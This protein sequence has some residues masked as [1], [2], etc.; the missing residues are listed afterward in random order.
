[1]ILEIL[2]LLRDVLDIRPINYEGKF[3]CYNTVGIFTT[4]D[5]ELIQDRWQNIKFLRKRILSS[6]LEYLLSKLT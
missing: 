3:F 6:F 2:T 1:M 4:Y 5:Y